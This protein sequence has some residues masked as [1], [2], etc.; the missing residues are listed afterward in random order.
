[1]SA[2]YPNPPIT[3]AV[4]ELRFGGIGK[5]GA[6]ELTRQRLLKDYPKSEDVRDLMS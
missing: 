6:L 3:E 5:P 1:M 2:P 4:I